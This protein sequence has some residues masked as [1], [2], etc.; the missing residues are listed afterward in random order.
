M[1]F[2]LYQKIT[3][4]LAASGAKPS[5]I[6]GLDSATAALEATSKYLHDKEL[7]TGGFA[8]SLAGSFLNAVSYLP[9]K[10]IEPISTFAGWLDASSPSVLDKVRGE[11]MSQWVVSK[12]PKRRYPG[13][14]IGSSSGG[15]VHLGAALGIP[16]L[17]QTLLVCVRHSMDLDEPKQELE[18]AKAPV[19]RLL[20]NN[21]DLWAYQMHDPNQDRLKVGHVSYFR[22][23]RSRLGTQYKQFLKQNLVPGGTIF[24]VECQY[25]WLS[26]QV[27]DRHLFQ[28]GGKGGLSPEDYFQNSQQIADFLRRRGSKHRQWNP[29]EPDRWLPES[30]WGFEPS[31]REDVEE[32]AREHGL[33]VC[34][35]LFND[36]QELSPLVADLYRWWYKVRGLPS[37]RLLVESFTYLQPWWALRLGLVPYWAVFNDLTSL[38]HL[39]NYLDTTQPYDEI[40]ANLFSNGLNSLG[41]ASIEQWQSALNRARRHGQ[42]VG[43]NPKTYPGDLGSFVRHYTELKKLDGRYPIPILEPLTLHQLDAFLAQAGDRYAVRFIVTP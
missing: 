22:L 31:L 25:T 26:T 23:K 40:Y 43:V 37:D 4:R 13:V 35:I 38:D 9:S 6:I 34:R 24:L 42:F 33:R 32:F 14:L 8:P 1:P 10:L 19:Q 41:I 36:P 18:W 27:A 3:Q 20:R 15:V 7:R 12:Y 5:Y 30:E 28:F 17:P 21:P 2:S 29:P 39:N 11:T 16:W